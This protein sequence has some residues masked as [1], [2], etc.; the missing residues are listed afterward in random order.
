MNR[1]EKGFYYLEENATAWS[2]PGAWASIEQ[3]RRENLDFDLTS[4]IQDEIAAD[5]AG[6]VCW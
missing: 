3:L 2:D 5:V 4:Y 1:K 6:G